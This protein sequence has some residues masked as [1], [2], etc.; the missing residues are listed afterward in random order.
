MVD[1]IIVLVA[2]ALGNFSTSFIVGKLMANIDIRQCGSGNAGSTNVLRTL[3]KKAAAFTLLGD[4]I[5]G[6]AAVLIATY[7]GNAENIELIT[8]I[9]VVLGHNYPIL[10]KF[11]GGKGIA[12][13]IG[14]AVIT[15]YI[16]ALICIGIGLIVLIKYKYV[17]L[18]SLVAIILFAIILSIHS[19]EYF[20]FG[21]ILCLLA[22][23]RHKDNIQRLLNGTE[24]KIGE[25]L[26]SL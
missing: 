22:V 10:L 23:Y 25:K 2:Y 14:V 6:V 24:R 26:N 5:K 20:L 12:T 8:G 21:A 16:V 19:I 13:T 17:S 3:G 4:S 11:K 1:V 9:A 15:N 7:F 18:A